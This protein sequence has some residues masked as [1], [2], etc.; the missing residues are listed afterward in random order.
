MPEAF[1]CLASLRT[2]L[3]ARREELKEKLA[4]G[5]TETDDATLQQTIGRCRELKIA[6]ER[7]AAQIKSLHAGDPDEA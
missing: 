3:T 6:L 5:S 7:V 4:N 1:Q 2:L